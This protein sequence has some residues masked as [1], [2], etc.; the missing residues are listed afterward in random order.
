MEEELKNWR[1]VVICLTAIIITLILAVNLNDYLQF[2]K[3]V[4]S[5]MTQ[6]TM[7]GTN[8]PQWVRPTK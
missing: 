1:V 4:D 3:A 8:G 5:G 2:A 7:P 6:A